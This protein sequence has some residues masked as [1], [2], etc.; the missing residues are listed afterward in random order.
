MCIYNR[1]RIQGKTHIEVT[2]QNLVPT[3]KWQGKIL[4]WK[5]LR[6]TC[7]VFFLF[8]FLI[9]VLW[10]D[11]SKSLFCRVSIFFYQVTVPRTLGK[12]NFCLPN[13]FGHLF[14]EYPMEN[15]LKGSLFT[16]R[17]IFYQVFLG[18]LDIDEL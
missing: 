9:S 2:L 3:K 8:C 11:L 7:I 10:K 17:L 4:L 16:S 13:I 14:T 18:A 5:I 15:S 6:Y 1:A 12:I